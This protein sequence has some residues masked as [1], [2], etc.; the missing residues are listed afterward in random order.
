MVHTAPVMHYFVTALEPGHSADQQRASP[1][2]WW[3]RTFSACTRP[4]LPE[5]SESGAQ[6]PRFH[7]LSRWSQ[8]TWLQV[9]KPRFRRHDPFPLLRQPKTR[10][11]AQSEPSV[12]KGSLSSL[13][14]EFPT[15]QWLSVFSSFRGLRI[16]SPESCPDF[17]EASKTS[18]GF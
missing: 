18:G 17:S 10:A 2:S 7:T 9:E 5:L 14:C 12:G 11:A 8:S 6:H 13:S 15:W 16:I 3:Q 4:G 1:G